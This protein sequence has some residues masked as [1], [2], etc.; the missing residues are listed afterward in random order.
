MKGAF[1]SLLQ[2]DQQLYWQIGTGDRLH[3]LLCRMIGIT[4]VCGGLYGLSMGAFHSW[5]QALNSALKVPLLL[6]STLAVTLPALHLFQLFL[7]GAFRFLQML[8]MALVGT[9]VMSILLA[10]LVPVSLLFLLSSPNY[11]FLNILHVL[12][13]SI[14]GGCGLIAVNRCRASQRSTTENAD[15]SWW[16]IRAWMVLYMFVGTQLAHLLS[17]FIGRLDKPFE[18]MRHSDNFYVHVF[19][20]VLDLLGITP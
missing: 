1:T 6:F 4:I 20:S 18:I 13:F 9:A 5:M 2:P 11:A 8:T 15:A 19:Q 12:I 10:G 7:G 14:A 17:P 16:V 3:I